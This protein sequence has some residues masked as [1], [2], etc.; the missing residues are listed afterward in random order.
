[1]TE[2]AAE[3]SIVVEPPPPGMELEV[4]RSRHLTTGRLVDTNEWSILAQ[5]AN[6]VYDTEFVPPGLRGKKAATLAC[7]L[8]GREQGLGPMTALGEVSVIDGRPAMSAA[9]MSA[10]IREAGHRLRVDL[11]HDGGGAVVGARARLW[12]ADEPGEDPHEFTFDETDAKAAGLAGKS[13]WT[14]WRKAMYLARAVSGI[15][16][17]AAPDVFIGTAYTAEELAPDVDVDE[18][19]ARLTPVQERTE[20]PGAG[21]GGANLDAVGDAFGD[22][23]DDSVD[24]VD[25]PEAPA[26]TPAAASPEGAGENPG[27]GHAT[28][29]PGEAGEPPSEESGD[30]LPPFPD[31]WSGVVHEVGGYDSYT[32]EQVAERL[33][34]LADDKLLFFQAYERGVAV[35]GQG[36][37]QRRTLL[38]AFEAEIDRRVADRGTG[39]VVSGPDEAIQFGDDPAAA[40]AAE[41]TAAAAAADPD[42]EEAEEAVWSEGSEPGLTF[43]IPAAARLALTQLEKGILLAEKSDPRWRTASLLAVATS[44][45]AAEMNEGQPYTALEQLTDGQLVAIYDRLPDEVKQTVEATA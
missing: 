33:D 18:D 32:V 3:E 8:Y 28:T 6:T 19:G 9:L 11:L 20:L 12:R 24:R 26:P 34:A 17:L 14:K 31:A 10:K 27:G 37:K 36:G 15:A 5:I 13:N 4:R 30:P 7:L 29:P 39:P 25:D 43:E 40:D 45:W 2:A 41:Q 38:R 21:G 23:V 22:A 1:M 35:Q 42:P 16:R 44:T